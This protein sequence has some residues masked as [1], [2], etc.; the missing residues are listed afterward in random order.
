VLFDTRKADFPLAGK[1]LYLSHHYWVQEDSSFIAGP[2]L[3]GLMVIF[4]ITA[5]RLVLAFTFGLMSA[6]F[7][8]SRSWVARLSARGYLELIR[9]TPILD[10][11]RFTSAVLSLNQCLRG[12]LSVCASLRRPAV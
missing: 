6:L 3:R 9:N 8:L 11:S 4:R 2:L 12:Y 1:D 5:V 7:R 10:I